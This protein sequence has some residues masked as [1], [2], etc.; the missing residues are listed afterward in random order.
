L[1]RLL[2]AGLVVEKQG[3]F[4]ITDIGIALLYT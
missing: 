4:E 2:N 1:Q 3:S